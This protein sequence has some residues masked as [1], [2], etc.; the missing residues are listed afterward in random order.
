VVIVPGRWSGA[1]LAYQAEHTATMLVNN[2]GF[3]CLSARVLVTHAGWPQRQSFLDA[4]A[5]ALA[6]IG[7]RRAY[8]PGADE[9]RHAFLIDHPGARVIGEGETGAPGWALVEGVDPERTDDIC[10]TTEAF[11]GLCAETALPAPNAAEFTRVAVD[12][13]N[14]VLWGS[15]SATVLVHPSSLTDSA[16]NS[17][18]HRAVADLRYGAVGVNLWHAIA[19][20]LGTTTWGAYPG[21]PLT[22]I[23]SGRGVVGNAYM[24][25][26]PQKSVVRGPFRVRP[27]PAWFATSANQLEVMRRLVAYEADPAPW[28]L[29]ALGRAALRR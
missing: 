29:P 10:F 23:Q 13:C 12:F 26:R 18:V 15:L 19:F 14:D 2:A 21:H 27:Q 24:F 17:A 25:D 5:A 6:R 16:T 8:Y 7:A 28:R 22:D 4:L 11:C 3:N 9:R 20:A 1:D